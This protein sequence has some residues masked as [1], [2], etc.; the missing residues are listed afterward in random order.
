M[1]S[2]NGTVNPAT[3]TVR[4]LQMRTGGPTVEVAWGL[5]D[6]L[7]SPATF[8]FSLPIEAPIKAAYV[9]NPVAM[10]FVTDSAAAGH[11]TLEASSAGVVKTQVID[12]SASVPAVAFTFP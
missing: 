1:R 2:V 3:T 8:S 7:V 12:A 6:D 10:N 5:V 9:A 11:Y 4:A